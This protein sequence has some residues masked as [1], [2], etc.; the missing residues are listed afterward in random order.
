MTMKI[1]DKH[2]DDADVAGNKTNNEIL[3]S[4]SSQTF[5]NNSFYG[6]IAFLLTGVGSCY[7]VFYFI[8]FDI[9]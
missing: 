8:Y 4:N 2:D 7:T 1:G 5:D 9:I 6:F 3:L